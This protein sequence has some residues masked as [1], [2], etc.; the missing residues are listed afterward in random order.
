MP[1]G[2][3]QMEALQPKGAS[4]LLTELFF[5]FLHVKPRMTFISL[6]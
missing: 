6:T 4:V 5:F 3:C 1:T 2:L